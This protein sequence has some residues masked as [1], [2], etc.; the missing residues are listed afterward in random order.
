MSKA[1]NKKK[2]AKTEAK[3]CEVTIRV[4]QVD[5]LNKVELFPKGIPLNNLELIGWLE[6]IKQ[7]IIA[8]QTQKLKQ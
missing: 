2:P 7:N 3:F 5:D 4:T 1:T 8:E 6:V